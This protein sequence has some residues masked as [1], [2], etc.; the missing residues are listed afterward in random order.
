MSEKVE[1]TER[2]HRAKQWEIALFSLNNSATNLYIYAFGF[3]TYYATGIAGLATLLVSNVLGGARLFDGIIDPAIGIIMDHFDTRWG[4][5]RP[6]MLISNIG[7]ILSF[8][9]IFNVHQLTG[10]T[11]IVVFFIALIFH[12]IV[13]SFQ[14]TVT[15]AA[16]P[17]LTNDPKQRPMFSVYDTIFSSIGVLTLM[18]VLVSQFLVPRN[19]GSF[20]PEF[21]REFLTIVMVGSFI[22]TILAIIGIW[23][24]DNKEFFGLGED[25]V[26]TKTLSDYWSVIKGNTPLQVLALSGGLVK[27]VAQF[28]GDQAFLVILFGIILG[29]FELSG[30][31]ALW[32][33]VPNLLLVVV[34]TRLAG[35]KGLKSS[36]QL[37]ILI[38]LISTAI[39]ASTIY[40]APDSTQIF[41][42]G[43]LGM[44][45]IVIGYIG[46]KACASYPSSI[47]L[48]MAAD[49]TDY[50]TARS[51]R[52]VSGLIGTVF[53]LTDSIASSLS[54]IIIGFIVAGMGYTNSYPEMTE[55]LTPVLFN[56]GMIMLFIIIG[57]LAVVLFLISRYPLDAAAMEKVQ[58]QIALRKT[59]RANAE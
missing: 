3:L 48:T 25:T 36:Y 29:N 18:Q 42:N 10:T 2:Y 38:S 43:G 57:V 15:K 32:L 28:I 47:V 27:F 56:G 40:F 20:T 11:Q 55:T 39:L 14:Q 34:F 16:Q 53:S 31:L 24:K 33:V 12:K 21:F 58:E 8:L 13:Y 7:L 26:E 19:G 1:N 17:A 50:E 6:L 52:F 41:G 23:R 22:L 30:T 37:S 51:G 46:M 35:N 4:K 44:I 9:M 59:Q 49:I 54:P 45:A 5:F